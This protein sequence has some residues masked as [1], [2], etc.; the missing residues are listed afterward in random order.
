MGR[1]FEG[2]F[3]VCDAVGLSGDQ[4]VLIP[5]A[6]AGDL[7][8]REDV[9]AANKNGKFNIYAVATVHEALEVLTGMNAGQ[10]NE[11]GVYPEGSLLRL[12][13]QRTDEFWKKTLTHP[14]S[15]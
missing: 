6:N 11:D 12:A 9:V 2:F 15:G 3:D 7:M 4:G 13:Q 14:S 8:L 5:M 1:M 10:A